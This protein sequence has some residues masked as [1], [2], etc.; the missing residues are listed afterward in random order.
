MRV[1]DYTYTQPYIP[2]YISKEMKISELTCIYIYT[3]IHIPTH[4]HKKFGRRAQSQPYYSSSHI[5]VDNANS[6]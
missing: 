3:H 2:M 6:H 4:I 1:H 5:A